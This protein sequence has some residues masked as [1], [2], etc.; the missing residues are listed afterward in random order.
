MMRK[1]RGPKVLRAGLIG[2]ILVALVCAVGMGSQS[3]V[4][5]FTT[6]RYHAQFSDAGGLAPGNDVT[7]SGF[8]IGTVSDIELQ[9]GKAVVTFLV[10]GRYRLGSETTAHVRT[11]TLLGQRVL[12]LTSEG[13]G[14]LRPGALIPVA[15]TSTPY[16][17]S[18]AVGDLTTNT[19]GTDTQ[20]LNASLDTLS[21]TLDHIAPQLGP[22]FDGLTQ[23]SRAL[24]DRKDAL[25][26]LLA[27]TAQV[28]G[29]LA[30]R[31]SAVNALILDANTLVGVL[32]DRRQAMVDLLASTTA[33]ARQLS[34]LVAD[35][36]AT[37]GPTLDRLNAINAML[38]KNQEN[39]AKALPGLAK[40]ELT[41]GE[42]VSS[43]YYYQAYQ[44]NLVPGQTL[45]PFLDYAFGFRRGVD[46]GQPPDNAGP[47]AEF[48]LP[49]N[50][51][52]PQ[53]G[54]HP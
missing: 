16:S 13:S 34:G 28:S 45:Q 47:R 21:T 30:Q 35:N 11:S 4:N 52:P 6:V 12:T 25:R 42:A 44:P 23:L 22:T 8:K 54:A 10:D 49:R 19:A 26:S 38:Q 41:Q 24:A 43:G 2:S 51:I 7:R 20:G 50:G 15:R 3:L 29:I 36:E 18:D 39:I 1:Y 5:L 32:N 37:L 31:S 33:V 46:Q 14:T 48:P 40:Y 53:G 9:R 17:L 27:G